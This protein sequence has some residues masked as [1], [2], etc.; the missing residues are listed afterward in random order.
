LEALINFAVE[1]C[2]GTEAQAAL[3]EIG[4]DD[5]ISQFCWSPKQPG[6]SES[7]AAGLQQ[8]VSQ[9]SRQSVWEKSICQW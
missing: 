3:D 2:S 4:F 8:L 7:A 6:A 9:Q 5:S 1:G